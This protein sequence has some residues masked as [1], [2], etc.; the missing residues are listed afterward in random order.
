MW[1]HSCKKSSNYGACVLS[2]LV[3]AAIPD[4]LD[5]PNSKNAEAAAASASESAAASERGKELL[6][7]ALLEPIHRGPALAV[8]NLSTSASSSSLHCTLDARSGSGTSQ[9]HQSQ[10]AV[11]R[12][13]ASNA[14]NL[15]TRQS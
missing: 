9:S 11:G 8:Y 14:F 2:A 13:K 1:L 15:P 7:R 4:S 12:S 10:P 6:G 3:S 5:P